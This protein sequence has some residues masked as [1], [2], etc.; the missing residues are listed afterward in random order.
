M[1]TIKINSSILRAVKNAIS[2]ALEYEKLTGRKLGITGEIGEVFVC[3]KFKLKLLQDPLSVGYD[4]IDNKGKH[5][6]IKSR[7]AVNWER[8]YLGK[9][10]KFSKHKFDYAVLVIMDK[11]YKPKEWR[12]VS[13]KKLA[14]ILRRRQSPSIREFIRN[15]DKI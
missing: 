15:A 6:Q 7:R 12:R 10:G 9:V 2:A 1:K 3:K 14:P 13:Y 4:A 5:Y 11:E 8:R